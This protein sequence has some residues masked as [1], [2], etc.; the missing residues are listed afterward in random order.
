[1]R[2]QPSWD[3]AISATVDCLKSNST[4]W[5]RE[6]S[7]RQQFC[8]DVVNACCTA[9]QVTSSSFGWVENNSMV[10]HQL[11][12]IYSLSYVKWSDEQTCFADE[13]PPEVVKNPLSSV[14]QYFSWILKIH[15]VLQMW[16]TKLGNNVAN[17][18]EIHVYTQ[19]QHYIQGIAQHVSAAASLV[20]STENLF[21]LKNNFLEKYE[22]LNILLLK[23]V[24]GDP[25]L[26]W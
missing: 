9:I 6:P 17:Y 16:K 3:H 14:K 2:L 23:Y 11:G 13:L 18:D 24:P 21:A 10:I 4:W 7:V 26:G 22:Q 15:Q 25:K 12:D 20:I 1:M 5:Q 19:K 8:L